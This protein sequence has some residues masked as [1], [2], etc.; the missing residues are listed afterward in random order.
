MDDNGFIGIGKIVVFFA[1]FSLILSALPLPL[2]SSVFLFAY[3][4]YYCRRTIYLPSSP[5][6]HEDTD[7]YLFMVQSTR[8]AASYRL[9]LMNKMFLFLEKWLRYAL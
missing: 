3:V 6:M 4:T 8:L 9:E 5:C 7:G 1:H 2:I